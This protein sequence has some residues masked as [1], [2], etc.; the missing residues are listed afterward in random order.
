VPFQHNG[1]S[2]LVNISVEQINEGSAPQDAHYLVLFDEVPAKMRGTTVRGSRSVPKSESKDR[3]FLE[4][5][6][7]A[8]STEEHLRSVIESKEALEEFQSANEAVLS[9]N[10]EGLSLRLPP[11]VCQTLSDVD[12]RPVRS[13]VCT[14]QKSAR[15][16]SARFA[17]WPRL[18]A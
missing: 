16:L 10:E 4:L 17:I 1:R 11:T 7:K 8:A 5:Q 18:F 3:K 14:L 15:L 12:G 9:A 6:R 13:N 2:K